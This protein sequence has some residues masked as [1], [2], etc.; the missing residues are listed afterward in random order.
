MGIKY[1]KGNTEKDLIKINFS[2][3]EYFIFYKEAVRRYIKHG[4][5]IRDWMQWGTYG[6]NPDMF[7]R[8]KIVLL[9]NMSDEHI[10][11]I[12]KTQYHIKGKPQEREFKKELKRRKKNPNLSLKE[13]H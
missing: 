7:T 6:K 2:W 1:L 3:K 4:E 13:T 10:E 9:K 12:L 11:A 5:S 8:I